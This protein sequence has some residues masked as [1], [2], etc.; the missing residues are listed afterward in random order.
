[1][2]KAS[3]YQQVR[4][5]GGVFREGNQRGESVSLRRGLLSRLLLVCLVS[6]VTVLAL[7]PSIALAQT[8]LPKDSEERKIIAAHEREEAARLDCEDFATQRAAQKT[9]EME[10]AEEEDR[11]NLDPDNGGR[12]CETPQDR[13]AEDGTVL[14][15]DTGGDRRDC[16]DF[17][18][19]K[20]AQSF[21]KANPSDPYDLDIDNNGVACEIAP[22][23]YDDPAQDANPV[24][25][26]RS[27]TDLD[28]KDFEYQQEAQMVYF[29]DESDPNN[30]DKGEG[31]SNVCS[32]LPILWSN[33]EE[34]LAVQ[35]G[36]QEEVQAKTGASMLLAQEQSTQGVGNWVVSVLNVAAL[37]LV[38]SGILALLI[39][40]RTRTER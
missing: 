10:L 21:L 29:Q 7:S 35:T 23:S 11:F 13:G 26:A 30:L 14:G 1:M 25:E 20:A 39:V 24:S 37:L 12:A 6:V 38:V 33:V 5:G 3:C 19:Q 15:A 40:W 31:G 22:V 36:G 17:P 9:L 8:V 4:E 2:S 32:D 18:S 28:C 27:N 34:V 16:I